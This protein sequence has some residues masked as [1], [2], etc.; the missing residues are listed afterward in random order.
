VLLAAWLLGDT[1][2][3][4]TLL[5]GALILGAVILLTQSELRRREPAVTVG[6]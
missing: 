4:L 1:L 6:D 3:P 5:G 2:K